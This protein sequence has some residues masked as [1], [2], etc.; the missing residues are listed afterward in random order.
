[1]SDG[2][3]TRWLR[4]T[5][6]PPVLRGRFGSALSATIGAAMD[7]VRTRAIDAVRVRLP[8][9]A[10]TDA[11]AFHGNDRLLERYPAESDAMYRARLE[12]AFEVWSGAGTYSG[13]IG[14]LAAAG[15]DA[16]V[17]DVWTAPSWWAGTTGRAW[18][19]KPRTPKPSWWDAYMLPYP[20][21]DGDT[22]WWSLFWVE[23]TAPG[24]LGWQPRLWG[25]GHEFGDGATWG[26]TATA[27]Q[28]QFVREIIRKWKSAHGVC[29]SIFVRWPSGHVV[30][31]KGTRP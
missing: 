27:A 8:K 5:L 20:P 30:T 3:F 25:D 9:Y 26:S 19:P 2:P 6:A 13:V 21:A 15:F 29:E 14:A 7:D 23:I 16:Q 1:M 22:L 18:P 11:L 24:P 12:R 4:D 31:W 17:F 28:V 10:P